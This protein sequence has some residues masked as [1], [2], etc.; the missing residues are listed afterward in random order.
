M[1]REDLILRAARIICTTSV[2]CK[3]HTEQARQILDMGG[4]FASSGLTAD[5]LWTLVE[6]D[7][8]NS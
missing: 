1:S 2:P 7:E 5:P 8:A 4:A 3:K 6:G